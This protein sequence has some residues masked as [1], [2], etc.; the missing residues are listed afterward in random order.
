LSD[1]DR[2]LAGACAY[3]RLFA[4]TAGCGFLARGALGSVRDRPDH[5]ESA[6][7]VFLTQF[8]SETILGESVGLHRSVT[9]TGEI[10][11]AGG[12]QIKA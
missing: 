8:F 11:K 3:L 2:V 10:I 9:R 5:E 7:A 12:S 6:R 4:L 1:R